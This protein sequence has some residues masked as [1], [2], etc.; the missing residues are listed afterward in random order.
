MNGSPLRSSSVTSPCRIR[1]DIEEERIC[2]NSRT[3]S[4]RGALLFDFA[5]NS[6]CRGKRSRYIVYRFKNHRRQE[7]FWSTST[8]YRSP[9]GLQIRRN[10]IVPVSAPRSEEQRKA[11]SMACCDSTGEINP[12]RDALSR[13][14]ETIRYKIGPPAFYP[15]VS[16]SRTFLNRT[17]IDASHAFYLRNF[18]LLD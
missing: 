17:L 8:C 2:S 6:Q 4:F 11:F 3:E 10:L 14:K 18:Y 12:A 9:S 1:T 15:A 7:S 13:T 16:G 5:D